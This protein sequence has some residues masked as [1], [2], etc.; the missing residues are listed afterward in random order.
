MI[1]YLKDPTKLYPKTPRHLA[2]AR[3]QDT[4]STYKNHKL[5]YT[6]TTDKFKAIYNSLKKNQIP[7]S[8]FN[9]GCE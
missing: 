9:K 6:L 8:K 1:L 2:S 5:F 3:R 7:R 4:K